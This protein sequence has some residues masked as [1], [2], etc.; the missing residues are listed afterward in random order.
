MQIEGDP[1]S[2]D[3][4]VQQL[5]ERLSS[6]PVFRSAA[7]SVPALCRFAEHHVFAVWDFMSLLK[8]LQRDLT[9]TAIPWT[10]GADAES[11]R[12]VNEIVLSEESDRLPDGRVTSHFSLYLDAMDEIGADTGPILAFIDLVAN[13]TDVG[14]AL[15]DAGAPQAARLFVAGTMR[16]VELDPVH[17]RAGAFLYG[18]EDPI[19]AMFGTFVKQLHE[20]GSPCG[21]LR[22]YL[23]RHVEADVQHCVLARHL[24]NR[25]CGGEALRWNEAHAGAERALRARVELWG[26]VHRRL[27]SGI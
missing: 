8:S 21:V 1:L 14:T 10:P 24:L 17:A 11:A 4:Q 26:A 22:L 18:R 7:A 16:S 27:S 3:T 25:L 23:E 9:C 5:R 13:G 12:L 6:H 15:A 20:A 19:P 2:S